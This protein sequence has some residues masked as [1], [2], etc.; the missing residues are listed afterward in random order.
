MNGG[1]GAVPAVHPWSRVVTSR[2]SLKAYRRCCCF[3]WQSTDKHLHPPSKT[4]RRPI[5]WT[6]ENNLSATRLQIACLT[7]TREGVSLLKR[8]KLALSITCHVSCYPHNIDN[9]TIR[10]PFKN[11]RIEEYRWKFILQ[12]NFVS[13][14]LEINLTIFIKRYL[15]KRSSKVKFKQH[16]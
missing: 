11:R 8:E 16:S 4:A 9:L 6:P 14:N 15:I 13:S 2:K 12:N 5:F 1:T 3:Y 10:N 7:K